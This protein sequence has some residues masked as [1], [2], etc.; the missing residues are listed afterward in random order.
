[1]WQKLS[2]KLGLIA[3]AILA[4]GLWT[5][6]VLSPYS[7]ALSARDIADAVLCAAVFTFFL[8]PTKRKLASAQSIKAVFIRKMDFLLWTRIDTAIN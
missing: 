3:L 8:A 2:S 1:M 7:S 4:I 5:W 6:K